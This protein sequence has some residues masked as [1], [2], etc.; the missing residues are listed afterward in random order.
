MVVWKSLSNRRSL[1][2]TRNKKQ[3]SKSRSVRLGRGVSRRRRQRR[4]RTRTRRHKKRRYRQQGGKNEQLLSNTPR[5]LGY[6]LGGTLDAA[7]PGAIAQANYAP[8]HG[9]KKC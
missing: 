5:S 6:S 3:R 9:Y 7:V 8:Y 4:R 1:K 2:F